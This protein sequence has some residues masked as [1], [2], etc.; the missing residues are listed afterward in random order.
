MSM[1]RE[2]IDLR[3]KIS[4]EIEAEMA[5]L[6]LEGDTEW[7]F[8]RSIGIVRAPI[9]HGKACPC[10][11][12]QRFG[13]QTCHYTCEDNRKITPV[14]LARLVSSMEHDEDAL[15][16]CGYCCGGLNEWKATEMLFDRKTEVA[17]TPCCHTE[18][19]EAL[20]CYCG[21]AGCPADND[22]LAQEERLSYVWSQR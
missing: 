11:Q 13:Y 1:S 18:A 6:K 14:E 10:S 5:N 21:E 9:W 8:N 7:A 17:V 19:T 2:E 4:K 16:Y 20:Q 22:G 12:C 15:Y 3:E